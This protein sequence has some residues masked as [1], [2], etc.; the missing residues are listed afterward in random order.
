MTTS[1]PDVSII[2]IHGIEQVKLG[3]GWTGIGLSQGT[4][5]QYVGI[6]NDPNDLGMLFVAC[7]PMAN[8]AG[9]K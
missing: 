6:F 1:R 4:R 8:G 2:S 5:I 9:W 7:V 3:T